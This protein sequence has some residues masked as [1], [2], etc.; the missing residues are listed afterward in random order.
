MTLRLFPSKKGDSWV[1]F[2]RCAGNFLELR[3]A[4][5]I[6]HETLSPPVSAQIGLKCVAAALGEEFG[7]CVSPGHSPAPFYQ[8]SYFKD[9]VYSLKSLFLLFTGCVTLGMLCHFP[10]T[11]SSHL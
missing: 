2:S 6:L 9:S 8:E 10:G 1:R 3:R 11:L 4:H 7:A 5:Q